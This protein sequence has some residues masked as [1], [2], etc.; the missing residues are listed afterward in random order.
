MLPQE[1]RYPMQPDGVQT[2]IAE[3]HLP[4]GLSRRVFGENGLDILFHPLEHPIFIHPFK[5][6]ELLS[7][8]STI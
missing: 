6:A 1:M 2:W 7:G 3:N 4:N 8:F 5:G